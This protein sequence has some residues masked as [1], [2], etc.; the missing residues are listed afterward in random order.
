MKF[1]NLIQRPSWWV[2]LLLCA[3]PFVFSAVWNKGFMASDEYWTGIIRYIPA[4]ESAIDKL[5]VDDDVKSPTQLLPLHAAAQVAL[6]GGMTHPYQQYAFVV[7]IL[8]LLGTA[9]LFAAF[10]NFFEDET[11]RRLA[12][13]LLALYFA[14]PAILTRPM[15]ES[16][17][18]P[19]LAWA[20]L[21]AARYDRGARTA[22]LLWGAFFGALAFCLR[23][24]TGICCLIFPLLALGHRRWKDLGWVSAW[25]V[26]LLVLTG[27]P[28]LWIRG[29][30]HH[31]LRA[32]I[33]YNVEHGSD[34]GSQPW[35]YYLPLLFLL[36]FGPWWIAKYPAG[37]WGAYGRRFRAILW[38]IV[39]FVAEHS[40]F[41]HKFER[42]LI[43]LVPL[44]VM[45]MVPVALHFLRESPRR[46]WRL[47]SAAAFGLVLWGAATFSEPQ[48]HLIRLVRFFDA[49]PEITSL[50]NV[51][52]AL[53][54]LPEVF[55]VNGR[56]PLR[57][58]SSE[59]GVVCEGWLIAREPVAEKVRRQ[60]PRWQVQE[61]FRPGVIEFWAYKLNPKHNVRRAPM[62]L[63]KCN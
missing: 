15:F 53:T 42:F 20:A 29:G 35:W 63:M 41:T 36:G 2:L 62:S 24:Q 31:S 47:I 51:D 40:L 22:D 7:L 32:L 30:F 33:G 27:L 43:P 17:S 5:F 11:E 25:G 4:Q 37:F 45:L 23:P 57:E 46:R 14:A 49:H 8:G 28:D 1:L 21:F 48:G 55:R 54:W 12:F 60:D 39:L 38:M 9:I 34:Y 19:F 6:A 26:V 59:G 16:M 3:A 18:A 13:V 52:E 61:S 44:I 58:A 50:Q 10:W 56:M